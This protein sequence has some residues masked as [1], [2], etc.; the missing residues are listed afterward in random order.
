MY[1]LLSGLD[2]LLTEDNA[3]SIIGNPVPYHIVDGKG[4]LSILKKDNHLTVY[5]TRP[6]V[7]FESKVT[8]HESYK[9]IGSIKNAVNVEEKDFATFNYPGNKNGDVLIYGRGEAFKLAVK[10]S[11]QGYKNVYVMRG[12]YGMVSCAFNVEGCE[13]ALGYLV[14]HEGLY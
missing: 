3:V 14:N 2:D 9:N 11:V 1:H 6:K 4:A 13:D 5:D 10:L 8:G 7:E 12:L